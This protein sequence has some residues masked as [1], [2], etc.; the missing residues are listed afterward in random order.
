MYKRQEQQKLVND[1]FE[2]A[3]KS[4]KLSKQALNRWFT[5]DYLKKNPDTYNKISSL[6]DTNN[7][8]NFLKVYSLFVNHK[9]QE[10]FSKIKVKTLVMTGEGDVGSTPQMSEELSKEIE[11]SYFKII[12]KGKHLCSIECSDK[13]NLEIKKHIENA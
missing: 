7:M 12:P 2:L 10:D 13:V 9:D 1:R 11:N 8:N 6:L 4:K 5:D 3:K